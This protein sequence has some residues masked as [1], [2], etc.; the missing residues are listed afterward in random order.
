MNLPE[1]K[2]QLL[3]VGRLREIHVIDSFHHVLSRDHAT[4]EVATV[5][6]TDS[7][8]ATLDAVELDVDLAIVIV[9]S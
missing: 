5:E 9:E 6:A 4:T 3:D 1:T 2:S 7:V 8:L